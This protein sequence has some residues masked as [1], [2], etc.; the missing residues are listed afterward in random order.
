MNLQNR[1]Y[2]RGFSLIELMV[3]IAII[4]ILAAVA[5]PAYKSYLDRAKI[6]G[7]SSYIASQLLYWEQI[8][9]AQGSTPTITPIAGVDTVT[10]NMDVTGT[11]ANVVFKVAE[12]STFGS[13]FSSAPLYITYIAE[14]QDDTISWYS[15]LVTQFDI[16]APPS[17]N[18]NTLLAAQGLAPCYGGP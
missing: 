18:A 3:V 4:A 16:I 1:L 5:I 10:F 6:T 13:A 12:G 7:L 11:T 14:L 17:Y 8:Y 2:T 9:A 15:C